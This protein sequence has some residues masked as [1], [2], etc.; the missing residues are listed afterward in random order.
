MTKDFLV[1]SLVFLSSFKSFIGKR[2][3]FKTGQNMQN[4]PYLSKRRHNNISPESDTTVAVI[5][6]DMDPQIVAP[7]HSDVGPLNLRKLLNSSFSS[8][9]NYISQC[10]VRVL[11]QSTY[12]AL[13]A[14]GVKTH[15]FGLIWL[16]Y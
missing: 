7:D 1:K 14:M 10:V 8:V 9:E 3:P 13:D 11:D 2:K 15:T 12:Q 4:N 16:F 6:T 5:T